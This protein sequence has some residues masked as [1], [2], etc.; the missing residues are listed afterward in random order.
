MIYP[1]EINKSPSQ[2]GDLKLRLHWTI[3]KI[4]LSL[5]ANQFAYCEPR[6][7]GLDLSDY[8]T[9][10]AALFKDPF[11]LVR[12]A[13]LGIKGIGEHWAHDSVAGYVTHAEVEELVHQLQELARENT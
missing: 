1:E 5:Q 3:G 13:E 4:R 6:V 7:N 8:K 2:D 9:I 11:G 10:E 12:P